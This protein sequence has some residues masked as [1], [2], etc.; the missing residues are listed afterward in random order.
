MEVSSPKKRIGR[1]EEVVV[2]EIGQQ[3][4]RH[5]TGIDL[6]KRIVQIA[7]ANPTENLKKFFWKK[8]EDELGKA[9]ILLKVWKQELEIWSGQDFH[10]HLGTRLDIMTRIASTSAN[11]ADA[12]NAKIETLQK[13]VDSLLQLVHQRRPVQQPVQKLAVQQQPLQQQ[14][15]QQIAAQPQQQ[16][17]QQ[18]AVQ[19]QQKPLQQIA[20]QPQ[21]PK[22]VQQIAVQPV[23]QIAAQPQQQVPKTPSMIVIDKINEVFQKQNNN[24]E[25]LREYINMLEQ[26]IQQLEEKK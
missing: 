3:K 21:Q 14:P 19:P 1:D 15:V 24:I 6:K 18:I 2:V 26:R 5:V 4:K 17:L 23:Q 13:S 20:D 7:N 22:P 16:P 12:N 25:S 9:D 10:E 8:Y 11:A